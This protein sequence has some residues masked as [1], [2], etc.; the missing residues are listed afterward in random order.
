MQAFSDDEDLRKVLEILYQVFPLLALL[1]YVLATAT[2]ACTLPTIAV[3]V[4]Y[5]KVS[6]GLI[7]LVMAGVAATY[8][9][10][11]SHDSGLPMPVVASNL[12]P[13]RTTYANV[14]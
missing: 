7:L 3:K 4:R 9:S 14:F 11:V 12:F 10:F 1:F 6:R 13:C 5:Q 2:S 8:V